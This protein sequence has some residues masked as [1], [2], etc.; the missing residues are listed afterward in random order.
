[1]Q[2]INLLIVLPLSFLGLVIW[3]GSYVFIM[4]S[5]MRADPREIE[6][7]TESGQKNSLIL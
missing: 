4:L 5:V 3:V 2:E 6:F 7:R 1:M